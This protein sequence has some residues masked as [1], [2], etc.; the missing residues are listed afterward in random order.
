[1]KPFVLTRIAEADI[2]RAMDWYEKRKEGPGA[3]FL[4]RV[5][6]SIEKIGLDPQGYAK[7]IEDV[8]AANLKQ[9]PY[10]LWFRE[11]DDGSLLVIACLH[12]RRDRRRLAKERAC[13]ESCNFRSH[14][15]AG[16]RY[17]VF[18]S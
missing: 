17:R 13:W 9:F 6:E 10:F 2:A 18:V 12:G 14:K 11:M 1:M 16:S 7:V 5:R 8:R 3:E 4:V 15:N